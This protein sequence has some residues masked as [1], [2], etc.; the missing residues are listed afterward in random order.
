M[1]IR[2]LPTGVMGPLPRD[3]FGLIIGRG[4]STLQGL[5]IYPGV[6]DNDFTGEIQIMASSPQTH[7]PIDEGQRV[8]QLILLPLNTNNA[9]VKSRLRNKDSFGSSDTYWVQS[10]LPQK[11]L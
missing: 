10:V 7:V 6:V 5:F 3:T 11:P 4:S 9:S 8:A 2:P 1:G